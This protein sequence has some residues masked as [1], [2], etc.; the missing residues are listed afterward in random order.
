MKLRALRVQI[1]A[2]IQAIGA[3]ISL[4][5][6]QDRDDYLEGLTPV[7]RKSRVE[8]ESPGRDDRDLSHARVRGVEHHVQLFRNH[9]GGS[10]EHEFCGGG[11]PT[12]PG[13]STGAQRVRTRHQPFELFDRYLSSV[14]VIRHADTDRFKF[15]TLIPQFR[16]KVDVHFEHAQRQM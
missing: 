15:G 6:M 14:H 8:A 16:G 12:V 3:A 10:C 1:K 7:P 13:V 11:K 4:R 9:H 5:S 2:G